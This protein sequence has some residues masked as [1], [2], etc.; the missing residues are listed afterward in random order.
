MKVDSTSSQV[1]AINAKEEVVARYSIEYLSKMLKASKLTEKV[2]LEFNK[3][4]PIHLEFA[5]RDKVKLGFIL[6]PRIE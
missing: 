3:D 2:K 1:Y 6:A 5:I 4:Y